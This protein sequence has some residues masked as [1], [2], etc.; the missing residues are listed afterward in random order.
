VVFVA[1]LVAVSCVIA[2]VVVAG[3]SVTTT[4]GVGAT[5]GVE[6]MADWQAVMV[7]KKMNMVATREYAVYFF[8]WQSKFFMFMGES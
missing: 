5:G 7:K 6:V 1:A 3:G 2:A 8:V 4:T